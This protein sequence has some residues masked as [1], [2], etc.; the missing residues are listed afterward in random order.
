M[1]FWENIGDQGTLA[2]CYIF[3]DVID[4][5]MLFPVGCVHALFHQNAFYLVLPTLQISG[6]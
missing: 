1:I 2:G 4:L 5:G 3:I 6:K